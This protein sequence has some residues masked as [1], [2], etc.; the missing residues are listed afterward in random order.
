M[1]V[2]LYAENQDKQ[3][4]LVVNPFRDD[5]GKIVIAQ[6]ILGTLVSPCHVIIN[7]NGQKGMYFA[8]PDI[9]CRAS[10]TFRL[11]FKL[12]HVS[13]IHV[14]SG[15]IKTQIFSNAFNVYPP[16]KF[17]GVSGNKFFF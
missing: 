13:D 11:L 8:F 15:H 9:S 4:D 7:P 6:A 2:S 1:H 10:G 16:K 3:L 12:F 14:Q 5:Q 17:P